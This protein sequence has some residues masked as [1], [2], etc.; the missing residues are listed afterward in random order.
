MEKLIGILALVVIVLCAAGLCL[1]QEEGSKSCQNN[2]NC[3]CKNSSD[4]HILKKRNAQPTDNLNEL[5]QTSTSKGEVP[6]SGQ[7]NHIEGKW[8][9]DRSDGKL[10][11][12]NRYET[13]FS[14]DLPTPLNIPNRGKTVEDESAAYQVS[15]FA[16]V[17]S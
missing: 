17:R 7:P 14:S 5:E 16:S 11:D 3:G 8:N 10:D 13:S 15:R 6:I 9:S 4:Y 2:N 1:L 12:K